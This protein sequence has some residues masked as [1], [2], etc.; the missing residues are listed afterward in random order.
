MNASTMR[1][2]NLTIY[3]IFHANIYALSATV[4]LEKSLQSQTANQRYNSPF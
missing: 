3:L 4:N 2:S 1:V